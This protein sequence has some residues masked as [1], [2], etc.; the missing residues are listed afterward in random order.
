M[1][2]QGLIFGFCWEREG[3]ETAGERERER[4]R[5]LGST[6]ERGERRVFFIIRIMKGTATMFPNAL[7]NT[8]DTLW[9]WLSLGLLLW[10]VFCGFFE[11]FPKHKEGNGL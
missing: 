10:M 2:I 3:A 7:G 11:I 9:Y 6:K 1:S 4:E 8:V 5:E